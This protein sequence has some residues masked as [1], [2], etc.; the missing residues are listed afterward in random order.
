MVTLLPV[1][2]GKGSYG[3]VCEGMYGGQRVA[4]KVV[5]D[6]LAGGSGGACEKITTT[7][8]Q[9]VEV[10]GRCRHANVVRLLAACM[11]PPRLCLVME[12]METSLQRLVFGHTARRLL[13]LRKVGPR[14]WRD[15]GFKGLGLRQCPDCSSRVVAPPA[16]QT[17]HRCGNARRAPPQ[18]MYIGCEI[19]RALE[20]LHPTIVHRDLKVNRRG[21]E[22][23]RVY[24]K[25]VLYDIYD[26]MQLVA[27]TACLLLPSTYLLG[28]WTL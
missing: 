22:G 23:T 10:M 16:I 11:E 1:I 14:A 25:L 5:R 12:L 21:R 18:V 3:K 15:W 20:Y 17:P 26:A 8:A 9:E 28:A 4:V 19:A 24:G 27:L 13:P 6:M 2:R 7:F